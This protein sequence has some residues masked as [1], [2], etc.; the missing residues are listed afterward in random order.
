VPISA[1]GSPL[2]ISSAQPPLASYLLGAAAVVREEHHHGVALDAEFGQFGQDAPDPL[3]HPID[4]RGIDRHFQV[5]ALALA[6]RHLVPGRGV[7]V[8]RG[9][10]PV[11]ADQPHRHLA[12]QALGT[13]SVPPPQILAPMPLDVLRET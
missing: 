2:R 10:R 8:A 7:L 4:L 6:S 1:S 9:Q 5:E 12:L 11:L 13:K 3:V